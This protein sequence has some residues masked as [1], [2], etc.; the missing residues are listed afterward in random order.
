MAESPARNCQTLGEYRLT[1][2]GLRQ[3]DVAR[4][5]RCLQGWI[6]QIERGWIPKPWNRTR[7]LAAYGLQRFE[8]EFVR[9]VNNAKKLSALRKPVSET[10]PLLALA[11]GCGAQSVVAQLNATPATNERRARA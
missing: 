7:I 6:S 1:V 11:S 2:L 8:T 4:Q 10:E 5:A 9:M 3:I